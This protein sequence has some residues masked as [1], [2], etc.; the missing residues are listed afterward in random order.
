MIIRRDDDTLQGVLRIFYKKLKYAEKIFLYVYLIEM[1]GYIF[2][3][4]N[5]LLSSGKLYINI[6]TLILVLFPI[7]SGIIMVSDIYL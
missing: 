7:I 4:F 5:F 2:I 6:S 1:I 3:F